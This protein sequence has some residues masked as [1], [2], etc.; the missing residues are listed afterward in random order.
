M[1]LP[2]VECYTLKS[3]RMY[4]LLHYSKHNQLRK[5]NSTKRNNNI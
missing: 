3:E 2:E 1:N 5:N 4:I